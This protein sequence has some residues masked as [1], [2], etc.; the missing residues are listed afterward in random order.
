M[1]MNKYLTFGIALVAMFSCGK[2]NLKRYAPHTTYPKAIYVE[3]QIEKIW[4]AGKIEADKFLYIDISMNNGR[5]ESGKL[6]QI[7]EEYIELSKGYYYMR[8]Q[9]DN[10]TKLEKVVTI[11]KSEILILKI[12]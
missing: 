12:W 4:T 6:I 7:S 10:I 1:K 5:K 2:S 11:P 3:N 9:K 8:D